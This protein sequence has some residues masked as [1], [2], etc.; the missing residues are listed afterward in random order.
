MFDILPKSLISVDKVARLCGVGW[1]ASADG[2]L[3]AG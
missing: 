2:S 1:A 3:I